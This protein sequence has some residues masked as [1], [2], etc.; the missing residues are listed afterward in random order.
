MPEME[1]LRGVAHRLMYVVRDHYNGDAVAEIDE[2]DKVV[3][4]LR[5][6]GV[7]P[8]DGLVEQKELLRGAQR[9]GEQHALLLSA[10]ERLIALAFQILYAHALKVELRAFT[11]RPAVVHT[12]PERVEAAGEHDLIN[13]RGKVALGG[14]LLREIADL[15]RAQSAAGDDLPRGGLF[16]AQKPAHERGLAGAVLPD[17]AE[18]IPPL[19]LKIHA[20]NDG[21]AVVG[22]GQIRTS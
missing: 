11:L 18:V 13:A 16:Q 20:L 3:H 4:L 10:G 9:T 12:P 1:D 7:K 6:D 21:F 14:A 8:G 5:G 19:Y 22:K 2:L 17:D 15:R